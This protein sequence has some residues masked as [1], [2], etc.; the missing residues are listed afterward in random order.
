MAAAAELRVLSEA[1]AYIRNAEALLIT[2]GAGMGVDSGLPDFRGPQGFWRAYPAFQGRR[3]EEMSNPTW[4]E[5][6]PAVAWG[7]F[8]HRHKLYS[9]T[10]PHDGFKILRN[11]A[12]KFNLSHFV[13]TSNVDGHFGKS[14]FD[15]EKIV[16]C[17]GS[18]HYLQCTS[19]EDCTEE[20]W[21]TPTNFSVKFDATTFRAEAPLPK[22]R[23]CERISRPNIL[24]FSDYSWV[25]KRT[26]RQ[27][28]RF[29]QWLKDIAQ[30]RLVVLEFGAGLGVPT[31]RMTGE[32]VCRAHKGIAT[33][34]RFNPTDSNVPDGH[35]SVKMGALS[36]LQ[37]IDTLLQQ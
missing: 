33:L 18:I 22:C 14:V 32:R 6:D 3:F 8:G 19:P 37:Q 15:S 11:W 30:K 9:S 21:D 2:A 35:L 7:F 17:H 16:E 23:K 27:E 10:T 20:I 25:D 29:K 4:F 36:A 28:T 31:V 12:E 24:M 1:A 5:K 34:I 26:S 13:F